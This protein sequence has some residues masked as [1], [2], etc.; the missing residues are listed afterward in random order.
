MGDYIPCSRVIAELRTQA[1]PLLQCLQEMAGIDLQVAVTLFRVAGS[2]CRMTHLARATP[3][4]L[5]SD[6]LEQFDKA[7]RECFSTS[8]AVDV[9]DGAWHQAQLGLRHG[10]LSL[11]SLSLHAPAAFIASLMSF[12]HGCLDNTCLQQAVTLYNAK[13]SPPDALTVESVLASPPT[14]TTLSSK[15][16]MNLFHGLLENA[17]PANKALPLI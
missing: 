17:S 10:G 15:I 12:G 11:R 7:V 1:K 16:D 13:V 8:L 2:Y 4:S 14:K 5:A 9:S 6:A 3:H